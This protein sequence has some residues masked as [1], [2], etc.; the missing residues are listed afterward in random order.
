MSF[1]FGIKSIFT[2]EQ[3]VGAHIIK[4]T[5]VSLP[6]TRTSPL[7]SSK[8]GI[9]PDGKPIFEY[10]TGLDESKIEYYKWMNED[11]KKAHKKLLKEHIE[12]FEKAFNGKDVINS[13]NMFF[14]K[15]KNRDLITV[16]NET[17]SML[18][19]MTDPEHAVLY[20]NIMSGGFIDLVA[21][22]K[23]YAEAN[24]LMHYLVHE[25]DYVDET[26]Q[27]FSLKGKA[28]Q[29]MMELNDMD[30]DPLYYI[31]W[32]LQPYTTSFAAYSKAFSK[33][34][35]I[36]YTALYIEG[37]LSRDK[38][39][40][41]VKDFINY[42]TN[43]KSGNLNKEKIM[44]EA[45]INGALYYVILQ[46]D[47][48]GTILTKTGA[49]VGSSVSEAIEILMKPKMAADLNDLRDSVTKKWNE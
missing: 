3:K 33:Q 42:A 32:C 41:C 23:E 44:V 22:S 46:K 16:T 43:W 36:K 18:F 47:R 14:W 2:P 40:N 37:K 29:L 20:F 27:D 6:F 48:E 49:S 13:R 24:N 1:N 7:R 45:Y 25:E 15:D 31:A 10:N 19:K 30:N 28:Y 39:R 34:E 4:G 12:I 21:P 8:V 17:E 9:H 11:E 26:S 35:L 5:G 38:K